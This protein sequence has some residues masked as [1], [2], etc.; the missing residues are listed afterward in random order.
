M[1]LAFLRLLI[2]GFSIYGYMAFC[3]DKI[4][5]ESECTP[6]IVFCG[7]GNV[8]FLAGI[9][10]IMNSAFVCIFAVGL[11][12]ALYYIWSSNRRK[13]I[14][15]SWGLSVLAIGSVLLL[16]FLADE[17]YYH[18]DNFTHWGIVIKNIYRDSAFPNFQDSLV[19]YQSYPLGSASFIW[20]ICKAIGYSE[21]VSMFAQSAMILSCVIPLFVF[22]RN[23]QGIKKL[24]INIVA[25]VACFI[26]V[27]YGGN[28]AN[29]PFNMLVD[30]LLAFIAIAAFGMVYYYRKQLTKAVL[31]ALPLLVFVITVK[32]SGIM[33]VV[34]ILIEFLYF[35]NKYSGYNWKQ[36]KLSSLL[37]ILPMLIR[38][39]WDKH[40][41]LVFATG[42]MSAHAMSAENYGSVLAEKT[43]ADIDKIHTMFLDKVFS[44]DNRIW[45]LLGVFVILLLIARC[46]DRDVIK[47]INGLFIP[48]YLMIV[49]TIYQLG[50]YVMYLVSMP[51]VE[52]L[53]LAGYSRYAFTVDFFV[54]GCMII[55]F[56]SI[57]SEIEASG[58]VRVCSAIVGG[59]GL[60]LLCFYMDDICLVFR[61]NVPIS[62]RETSRTHMDEIID[63][64]QLE[65]GKKSLVYIGDPQDRDIG[66]RAIMSKFALYSK[67][68][69]MVKSSQLD[70]LDGYANL[71]YVIILEKDDVVKNYLHEMALPT[72]E[73]CIVVSDCQYVKAADY[74]S[75][76]KDSNY[77]VFMSVKDDASISFTNEM[78]DAMGSLGLQ[79]DLTNQYRSSYV[80]VLDGNEVVFENMS[81]EAIEYSGKTDGTEY[82]VSSAGW[83]VGNQSQ[84]I[85]NGE[86]YSFNSRG[87]NIV[88]YDKNSKSV[89]DRVVFDTWSRDGAWLYQ[90]Q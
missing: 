9:L 36:L 42:D 90:E 67:D 25:C 56:L 33:W 19:T 59:L 18:Y 81:S 13:V 26:G 8:V 62:G 46:W 14:V 63:M 5:V 47:K 3:R 79:M 22:S 77:L 1:I 17:K 83:Q 84:I 6:V 37:L 78:R 87:I 51:L 86:D 34:A 75:E 45:F 64:Y 74:I 76:L 44:I 27:S 65:E 11:F 23:T 82:Y 21:G 71:D 89:V 10:N 88:V 16:F 69:V 39:L 15:S 60:V 12:L 57:V 72:D 66:Y 55:A 80:A 2:L 38:V 58:N 85:V 61:H 40:V 49:Y 68:V 48:I 4:G 35:W 54:W 28:F 53:D 31:C 24:I 29:D 30:K 70:R 52:A 7:I 73:E 41:E 20:Y 43:A 32:N 50:N